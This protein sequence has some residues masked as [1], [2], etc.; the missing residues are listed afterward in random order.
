MAV[1]WVK[2]KLEACNTDCAGALQ[3]LRL[4]VLSAI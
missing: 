4:V 2:T 3:E 1:N